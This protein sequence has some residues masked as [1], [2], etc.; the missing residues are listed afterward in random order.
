MATVRRSVPELWILTA[1]SA[2]LH[3][4]RLSFPDAVVFDE[5]YYLRFAGNDLAGTF[6]ADV[7][8][9]LGRLLFA[10]TA[11]LAG[12]DPATLVHP[13]ASPVL[14]VL[15]ALAGTL[16]VPLTFVLLRQLSASRQTATL[17]ALA[18]LFDNALLVQSRIALPDIL[19]IV[20]GFC[21]LCVFLASRGAS[22]RRRVALLAASAFFAGCALSVKWTG[23]SALGVIMAAWFAESAVR[24]VGLKR[25]I[26]E[27]ALLAVV[28]AIVYLVC[29]RVEIARI[30]HAAPG[31]KVPFSVLYQ[32]Q[33]RGSVSYDPAARPLSFWEKLA[34]AHHFIRYGN[35][36]LERVTHP[37][38]SPW[39]TWPVMKHPIGLW[40]SGVGL[41]GTVQWVILLGNPIVWW[42]VLAGAAL[43][44]IVL[45]RRRAAIGAEQRFALAFLWGAVLLNF[46]PFMAIHRVMY[47]YHYLFALAL[48]IPLAA[49]S[50]GLAMVSAPVDAPPS[51]F[52]SRR[53][54]VV[55]GTIAAA[56]VAGFVY[57]APLTYGVRISNASY[58]RHFQVLHPF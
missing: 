17:A 13:D 15:P 47:L 51:A 43:G 10:A 52:T 27:G 46:V 6:F 44:L 11:K 28:P 8:P 35:G 26:R 38:S 19:L 20:F 45:A 9:P 25:F 3:F 53:V 58:E 39:Y 32:R 33:L 14:R 7:H 37:A 18:T 41:D 54:A 31:S 40:T 34:E 21:A 30:D 5:L 56:I 49:Y 1:L 57:F 48:L 24:R 16:L 12:V 4:A 50:L 22:G 42:G 29:W 2:V 23:A 55:Y 36:S